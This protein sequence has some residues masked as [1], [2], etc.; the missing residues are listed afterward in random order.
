MCSLAGLEDHGNLSNY[1]EDVMKKLNG[2]VFSLFLVLF[3]ASV[4]A[5]GSI[6]ISSPADKSTLNSGSGN[7][8]VFNI[9]LSPNGN[10]VHIYVDD[11]SPIVDRD[12]SKCPCTVALPNLSSGEHTIAIKEATASHSLTGVEATSNITVK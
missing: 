9:A 8:L 1:K 2:L 3:N 7:K 5:A 6:T 12:I 4:W 11:M 10:H